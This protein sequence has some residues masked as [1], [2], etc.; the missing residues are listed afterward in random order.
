VYEHWETKAD[1]ATGIPRYTYGNDATG[2][3][4]DTASGL[5]MLMNN[6]A[7]GLR[8]AISNVDLNVIAPTINDTFYNEML[9]NPDHSI[10]GDCIIVP[11]GA[12]AILV[13]ESHQ[14]K[15]L[16]FLQLTAN[17]IDA[18]IIGPKHRAA[19]LREV[20][21]S[22]DLP[23]DEVVPTDDEIQA[24]M[25]MQQQAMQGQQ[26]AIANMEAQKEAAIAQRENSAQQTKAMGEIVK[27][28]VAS[29]MTNKN[30][31]PDSQGAM[32]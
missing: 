2:G 22:L 30:Q 29:A 28:S 9:Y 15:R 16:Q 27:T 23:V 12:A 13:R 31:S 1:D 20:A 7:K 21:Q 14:S 4:A 18:P 17:P 5:S 10:K 6:A 26:Q 3:S 24:N 8:R 11:R 19:L 25:A 32:P